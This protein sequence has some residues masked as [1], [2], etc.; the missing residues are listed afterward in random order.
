MRIL[1]DENYGQNKVKKLLEAK[2][3]EVSQISKSALK[4]SPDVR[5]VELAVEEERII[6]TRDKD[7]KGLHNQ[8]SIAPFGLLFVTF[9]DCGVKTKQYLSERIA[10]TIDHISKNPGWLENPDGLVELV[11]P[12]PYGEWKIRWQGDKAIMEGLIYIVDYG[13]RLSE[14]VKLE[15][16]LVERDE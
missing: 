8:D 9:Y 1:F 14:H 13:V 6:V 16:I 11:Q 15:S 10:W 5:V 4:S 2:G 7:Y 12:T 3:Y